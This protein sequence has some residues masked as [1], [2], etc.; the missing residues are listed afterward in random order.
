MAVC[1]REEECR[2][3]WFYSVRSDFAVLLKELWTEAVLYK[4]ENEE[5]MKERKYG[6]E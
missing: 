6:S 5:R 2:T 4:R 3:L 1:E